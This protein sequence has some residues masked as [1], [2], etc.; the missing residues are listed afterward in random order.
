[1]P[2]EPL[3]GIGGHRRSQS[4]VDAEKA[5]RLAHGLLLCASVS[6][7]PSFIARGVGTDGRCHYPTGSDDQ[8][9]PWYLGLHA[10][11]NSG[12]PEA[13]EQAKIMQAMS[14]VA[15]VL[16]QAN[17]KCPCDGAFQGQSRGAFW[18]HLFRDA[19]RYLHLLRVVESVT[20]NAV[21]RDRYEKALSEKPKDSTRT[22]AEICAQGYGIDREAIRNLD[23]I[24]LWIYVGSQAALAK[25]VELESDASIR[26]LYQAGLAANAKN[27]LGKV[28]AFSQFDNLDDKK[29]GHADWRSVYA[30]WRPQRTQNDAEKLAK[31]A[32][33]KSKAGRRKD[34]EAKFMRNPLAA[35]AILAL[36][37]NPT[38]R[39]EIERAIA[40]YD[41]STLNMSEFFFAECAY[42]SLPSAPG[43]AS[44]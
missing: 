21:W 19:V 31:E 38:H 18:G 15:D 27:A 41:Y 12:I 33:D 3:E 16:N 43:T 1:M 23:D 14:R 2:H 34:Y 36:S 40:H 32:E 20:G 10:Y 7:V 35:A 29:F 26:M 5:R 4:A 42:Y 37:G 28:A 44:P 24:Q 8:T 22:R 9:H 25:L 30:A 39:P 17:W 6:D 13:A 11:L